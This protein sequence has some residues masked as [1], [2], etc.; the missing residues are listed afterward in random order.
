M[1]KFLVILKYIFVVLLV[2]AAI[3][4]LPSTYLIA[5]GLVSQNLDAD[6][7]NHFIGKLLVNVVLL[8]FYTYLAYRLIRNIKSKC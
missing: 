5:A 4:R 1:P 6:T 7:S 8:T 3:E 2:L